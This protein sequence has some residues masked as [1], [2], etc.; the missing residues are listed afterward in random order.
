M[1]CFSACEHLFNDGGYCKDENLGTL[2]PWS[3]SVSSGTAQKLTSDAR[4][5]QIETSLPLSSNILYSNIWNYH[6]GNQPSIAAKSLSLSPGVLASKLYV[7][8]SRH[9][10]FSNLLNY[11]LR[12][13]LQGRNAIFTR[14]LSRSDAMATFL[15]YHICSYVYLLIHGAD[16]GAIEVSN[17]ELTTIF[18]DLEFLLQAK[19]SSDHDLASKA[20]AEFFDYHGFTQ[21]LPRWI[22][23]STFRSLSTGLN[24]LAL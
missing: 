5:S 18:C 11:S 1:S 21:R 13:F 3:T 20:Y 23:S 7:P 10:S 22:F 2:C 12:M 4:P 15:I 24:V 17:S 8:L 14:R 6:L 19:V 9:E 16:K